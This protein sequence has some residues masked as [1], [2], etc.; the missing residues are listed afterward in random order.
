MVVAFEQVV[1]RLRMLL[2]F[3]L[4][5]QGLRDQEITRVLLA[6]LNPQD[7]IRRAAAILSHVYNDDPEIC[8]EIERVRKRAVAVA[9]KRSEVLHSMWFIGYGS[10]GTIAVPVGIRDKIVPGQGI[11][12]SLIEPGTIQSLVKSQWEL[13][14]SLD[15]LFVKIVQLSI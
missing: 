1:G 12:I 6:R 3:V 5:R 9:D 13:E 11:G 10:G 2:M 15:A 4:D 14:A 8:G 7:L